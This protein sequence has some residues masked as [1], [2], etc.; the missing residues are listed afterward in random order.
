MRFWEGAF[1]RLTRRRPHRCDDCRW[2]GWVLHEH[3]HHP[4]LHTAE[5][6]APPQG[7]PDLSAIDRGIRGK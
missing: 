2:R 5:A 3:G 6:V 4:R 7:D 1:K